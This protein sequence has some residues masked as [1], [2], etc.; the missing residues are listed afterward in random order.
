M[1][2]LFFSFIYFSCSVFQF[3]GIFPLPLCSLIPFLRISLSFSLFYYAKL[4]FQGKIPEENRKGP[5][6][7]TKARLA[8]T[9]T[10][11]ITIVSVSMVIESDIYMVIKKNPH[12]FLHTLIKPQ[13]IMGGEANMFSNFQCSPA[14]RGNPGKPVIW[15]V[16]WRCQI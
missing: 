11:T 16:T 6:P 15:P 4:L 7:T 9:R 13:Y 3:A 2:L 10:F 1:I 12:T 14:E 5:R 8:A